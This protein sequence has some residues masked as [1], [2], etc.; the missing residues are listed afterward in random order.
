MTLRNDFYTINGITKDD[1]QATYEIGL[2]TNHAIFG[3]HFPG[4]PI[5][6]GVCILQIAK[7]LLE[8]YCGTSLEISKVKNVKYLSIVSPLETPVVLYVFDKIAHDSDSCSAQ[9]KVMNPQQATLAKISFI[10]KS[11]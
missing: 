5:T 7:E 3:A 1:T 8:D 11:L 9:V 2:N 10:C 6:P 4:K